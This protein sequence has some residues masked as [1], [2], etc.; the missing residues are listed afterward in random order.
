MRGTSFRSRS[1]AA[2]SNYAVGVCVAVAVLLFLGASAS[3]A[4][5]GA[6]VVHRHLP[7][8]ALSLQPLGRLP[9]A[10]R[11]SLIIGLPLRNREAL[12]NLLQQLY[13]PGS[14]QFHRYLTPAQ[15]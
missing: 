13:D 4:A 2:R 10:D 14:P 3:P 5:F 15:F 8:A 6:Q 1:T 9:G 12:T 11:L 7:A